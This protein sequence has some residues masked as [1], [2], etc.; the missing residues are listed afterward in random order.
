[1]KNKRKNIK[2]TIQE[3]I[4]YWINFE[5]ECDLNFDWSEADTVCWRCGCKRKLQKCHI[6]PYS[7]GGKD[8]PS[9][10]VLLCSECHQE[11]PNVESP[12]FMWDWIKSF[13]NT[14]YDTFW[15][16]R[17]LQEYERIYHKS[18]FEELNERNIITHHAIST[19]WKLKIGKISYHF[20]HPYGN[21]STL[22]GRYKLRLDAFD[23]K[24]PSGKY[25]S[26]N[27]IK[28]E[29]EFEFFTHLFCS[30]AEKYNLCVW[31]G[32]TRNPY[33]LCMSSFF[34]KVKKI[35]GISIKKKKNAYFLCLCNEANPNNIPVS[36]YTIDL[37]NNY[38]D[39]LFRIENEIKHLIKTNGKPKKRTPYYFVVNSSWQ[40]KNAN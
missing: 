14:F 27:K 16:K 11:A 22:V 24:Y 18:F 37:G 12:T 20:G 28:E 34:P 39:V 17:A 23:A 31:E 15:Q 4:D 21:V 25:L 8:E 6:I 29:M 32:A 26:D 30:F 13:H 9:N 2:T 19:F 40:D 33:S 1:M 5:D 7:L 35:C 10:L 36:T 3:I 38:I